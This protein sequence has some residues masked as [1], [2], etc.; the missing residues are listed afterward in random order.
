MNF[1]E[2][3]KR[4]LLTTFEHIDRLLA[5]TEQILS[6]GDSGS[7]FQIYLSDM[8]SDGLEKF[9]E[10]AAEFRAL[11]RGVL[12]RLGISPRPPQLSALNAA[13]TTLDFVR[14]ALEELKSRYMRG[15]GELT[16][17]AAEGL[18]DQV[19]QMQR[20]IARINQG[21]TQRFPDEDVRGTQTK[22]F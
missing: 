9:E 15:Y 16:R 12:K 7:L 2:N 18:D 10:G 14:I 17:E 6:S 13:L 22:A 19:A 1:N 8:G 5:D 11:M 4:H 21:M 3:Q 20:A